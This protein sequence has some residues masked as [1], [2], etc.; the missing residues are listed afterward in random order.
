MK[1]RFKWSDKWFEWLSTTSS[2]VP[3]QQPPGHILPVVQVTQMT[4]SFPLPSWGIS[5]HTPG[6]VIGVLRQQLEQTVATQKSNWLHFGESTEDFWERPYLSC[7]SM[8]CQPVATH[9]YREE[10]VRADWH[11][12]FATKMANLTCMQHPS[13][14]LWARRQQLHQCTEGP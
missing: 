14:C 3:N 6:K 13:S 2:V 7:G 9:C 11:L 8:N 1:K 4:S 12:T 10:N 5:S